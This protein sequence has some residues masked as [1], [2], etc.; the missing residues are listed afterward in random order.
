MV[1]VGLVQLSTGYP[2]SKLSTRVAAGRGGL[3]SEAALAW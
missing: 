2:Q 3:P 1:P